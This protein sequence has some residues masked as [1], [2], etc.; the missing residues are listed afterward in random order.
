MKAFTFCCLVCLAGSAWGRSFEVKPRLVYSEPDGDRQRLTLYLPCT[1]DPAP[2]PGIILIHGGAW[3]FGTR[4]Q[5]APYGRRLAENGYAAATINYRLM[6]G[7]GFPDCLHDAKAAV[8]WMRTHAAEYNIDPE[9]IGVIGN[10]AGGHLATLLATTRP[11]DGLEGPVG[12]PGLEVSSAVQACVSLYG[13]ADLS[14]YRHP[15]GYIRMAGITPVFMRHFVGEPVNH[16]SDPYDSA[17]PV[18][19]A[20]AEMCPVLFVHGTRD[21]QVPYAQAVSF[22]EQLKRLGVPTR[23]ITVPYGHAFDYLH[24][25]TRAEV[26]GEML[27]FLDEHLKGKSPQP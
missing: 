7:H 22:C 17:S 8:R 4:H 9:R 21:H 2:R 1:P 23:L 15:E 13:V 16:V 26:F 12:A 20:H 10:S 25:N 18:T 3:V 6:P 27:V 11:E 19:Y 5:L 24:L 14:Y